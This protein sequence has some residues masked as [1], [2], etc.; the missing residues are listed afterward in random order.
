M[1]NKGQNTEIVVPYN[2]SL[3]KYN[4]TA[5]AYNTYFPLPYISYSADDGFIVNAGLILHYIIL[6]KRII[7]KT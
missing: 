7:V 4:R 5:F 6:I 3:Y 2:K 1:V